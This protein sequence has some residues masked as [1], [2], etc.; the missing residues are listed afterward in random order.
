MKARLTLAAAALACLSASSAF[1]YRVNSCMGVPVKWPTNGP[2]VRVS[3]VSFPDGYWRNG[4]Q[5]AVNLTNQNPTPFYFSTTTDTDGLGLGNGQS[6]TWGT[7]DAGIL[8]GSPAITYWYDTC[9]WFFGVVS[10]RDEADVIFDYNSPFQWTADEWKYSLIRYGGGGRQ[11]QGTGV[12]E[13]GHALGLLHV[14]TEYNVMGADFEHIWANGSAAH[15]YLGED[16]ADGATYLYGPWSYSWQDLGVAHWKYSYASGEYSRH[17]RT[18]VYDASGVVLPTVTVGTE[19]G[20]RVNKGQVVQV[21]FTYENNGRDTQTVDTSW[22]LSSDD[23]ITTGDRW[24]GTNY[25]MTLSRGDVL[26]YR[27]AVT[28]PSDLVSGGNYWV[29]TVVDSGNIVPDALRENNATYIPIRVN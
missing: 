16:A 1:A 8:N 24:L 23:Y 5:R 2:Q 14:N 20:Y 25:G 29:G 7:T 3:P 22:Y 4:L 11:L 15:G 13:F 27:R 19:T 10:H 26:T 9:Y 21:E 12:H 17:V 6:E 28:I 18:A